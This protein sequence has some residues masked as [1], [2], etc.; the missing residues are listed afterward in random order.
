MLCWVKPLKACPAEIAV[1][2]PLDA[3]QTLEFV[4]EFV[5]DEQVM[6]EKVVVVDVVMRRL[7]VKGFGS[8]TWWVY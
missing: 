5:A 2:R 6:Q 1:E 8:E 7:A 4:Q 3:E